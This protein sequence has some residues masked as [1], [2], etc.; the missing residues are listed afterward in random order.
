MLCPP[1]DP[2]SPSAA[3]THSRRTATS[4]RHV[5][6][7]CGRPRAG[8]ASAS[9]ASGRWRGRGGRRR[10]APAGPGAARLAGGTAAADPNLAHLRA[11]PAYL[12]QPRRRARRQPGA[13]PPAPDLGA[14]GAG[15]GGGHDRHRPLRWRA[16]SAARPGGACAAAIPGAP[17]WMVQ[18]LSWLA[19]SR[20]TPGWFIRCRHASQLG[21]DHA[22]QGVQA[23]LEPVTPP[24]RNARR[25]TGFPAAASLRAITGPDPPVAAG[26]RPSSRDPTAVLRSWPGTVLV[27]L[28]RDQDRRPQDGRRPGPA[29]RLRCGSDGDTCTGAGTH[30]RE[31]YGYGSAFAEW[32]P[33]RRRWTTASPTGLR[34][35]V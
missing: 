13:R 35:A 11:G 5:P 26:P 19:D 24:L 28:D 27:L 15:P 22:R 32:R 9:S 29:A 31:L 10:P 20:L 34:P 18:M 3:G 2:E 33:S 17:S 4:A 1:P 12:R 21:V 6:G 30:R 16:V 7:G 8:R 25:N 23:S 14:A